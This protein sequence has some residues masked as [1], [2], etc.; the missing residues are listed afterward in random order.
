MTAL[1]LLSKRV[2]SQV[3]P[4][5]PFVYVFVVFVTFVVQVSEVTI[6]E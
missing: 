4:A 3:R 5:E 1:T 6:G 2:K